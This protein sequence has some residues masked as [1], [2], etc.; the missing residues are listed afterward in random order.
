MKKIIIPLLV[1]GLFACSKKD[2]DNPA[3]PQ[4]EAVAEVTAYLG[5]VDSL[6]EFEVAF[7]KAKLAAADV[8]DGLT[9]FAPGNEAIGSYDIGA[10][11]MGKDLP[12]SIIKNHIVKGIFKTADLTDGKTLTTLS[13][14]VLKVK[15]INGVI[16]VNGVK[17]TIKDGA[18]GGQIIHTIAAILAA[19]TGSMDIKV[20]DAMQWSADNRS[21]VAAA[22]ASVKLYTTREKYFAGTAD[23]EAAADANGVA[24]F[25][26]ITPGEYF[27]VATKGDLSSIWPDAT[28]STMKS[29]DSLYQSQEEVTAAHAYGA[30]PGDFRC[31]DL[32]QDGVVNG[33]DRTDAPF[34]TVMVTDSIIVSQKILIGYESN[35]SM[36]AFKTVAEAMA[37]LP[38]IAGGI[39]IQQKMLVMADGI[40]SDDADC[41]AF[42]DWCHF[43]QFTF[44]ASDNMVNGIWDG[45]Y[46]SIQKLNRVIYSLP[47]ITG[48]TTVLAA[49][50]RGL[51]AYAYLELATYFGELPINTDLKMSADISRSSL[52]NTYAFI[53][54]ELV[55]AKVTLPATTT[56]NGYRYMTR[57]AAAALLAR[58]AIMNNDFQ[59]AVTY[60]SEVMQSG[61]YSLAN[62]A[63]I[64]FDDVNGT[65][66]I[67]DLT[68]SFP[69]DF[70][71]YFYSRSFCPVTR[72]SEVYLIF[73]E[74]QTAMN[75]LG[76]AM[77]Y[78]IL[79]SHRAGLP[80]PSINNPD[81][82][83][84]ALV[85]A[86]KAAFPREG[87]RFRN[88]VRWGL[89]SQVLSNEGYQSYHGKLPIPINILDQY[90]NINQNVGYN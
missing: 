46:S 62:D 37:T 56:V 20:F 41:S 18:A 28:R 65:E 71:S 55:I 60:A 75:N 90:P 4:S 17:I 47:T 10:R 30:A 42:P 63:S 83:R 58:I 38:S 29:T 61:N 84:T 52:P 12:D 67:W 23:Y 89:A 68:Q 51:R 87:Y 73:S 26:G 27:I 16:Y 54:N 57:G 15:V 86:Y 8:A 33:A 72:L 25:T 40:M 9:I 14:K 53:K 50:A 44:T 64:T 69:G 66:I 19:S 24:H 82:A 80:S 81:E 78:I 3:P 34:R 36:K 6:S 31:V 79:I 39:G 77:D 35:S 59:A 76:S 5:S 11:T 48:D 88:L 85:A 21:G 70:Y 22:S 45:L 13:G 2:K 43:N 74:A 49:Q 7:K 1:C 32:N